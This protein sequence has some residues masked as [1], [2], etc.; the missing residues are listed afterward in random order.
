[1]QKTILGATHCE[2]VCGLLHYSELPAREKVLGTFKRKKGARIS[3]SAALICNEEQVRK[4]EGDFVAL[5]IK[6][7]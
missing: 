5:P 2:C 7:D 6:Q 3:V 1:L 4:F